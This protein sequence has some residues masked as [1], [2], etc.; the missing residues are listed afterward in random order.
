VGVQ[1]VGDLYQRGRLTPTVAKIFRW[2][3]RVHRP[4]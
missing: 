1:Q 2:L 3:Y 4:S